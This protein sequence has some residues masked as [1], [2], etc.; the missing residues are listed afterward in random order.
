LIGFDHYNGI[1][2]A[3]AT[4]NYS[5]PNSTS[6]IYLIDNQG[7]EIDQVNY[8]NILENV[9]ISEG[10]SLERRVFSNGQCTTA[11]G[12]G[13]F[14]GNGC[15]T[16][17]ASDFEIRDIPN[18]QNSSSF[19]EPRNGP[20]AVQ[21]FEIQYSSST[22]ELIFTWSPSEDCFGATSTVTYKITD[23]S[24]AS[25]TLS[26]IETASTTAKISLKETGEYVVSVQAFDKEGLGSEI[27]EKPF[28]ILVRQIILAQQLDDSAETNEDYWGYPFIQKLSLNP[29]EFQG[30][31]NKIELKVFSKDGWTY[32]HSLWIE[33][34][35]PELG[36]NVSSPTLLF[37]TNDADLGVAKEWNTIVY[38][39]GEITT[40]PDKIYELA[41]RGR[42]GHSD[43]R[44]KG[45]ANLDSY[46]YGNAYHA[47]G[48]D[49]TGSVQDLYFKIYLEEYYLEE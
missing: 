46:P 12:S 3:D 21:G 2:S 6:T 36:R 14:L 7:S 4:R 35:D 45:S 38:D 29:S 32:M 31:F 49:G 48:R 19:P 47:Y 43:L 30:T 39:V 9:G 41:I 25:S 5:L 40:K 20:S 26:S 16:D 42:Y 11:S 24:Q 34:I 17:S 33:E 15:D 13:E 27:R 28:K 1:P 18:P 44:V 8:S 23:V 10:Q 22:K 37:Y